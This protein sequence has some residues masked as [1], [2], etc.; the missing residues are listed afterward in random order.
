MDYQYFEAIHGSKLTDDSRDCALKEIKNRLESDLR[1]SMNYESKTLVNNISQPLIV[2]PKKNNGSVCK[3]Q[4]MPNGSFSLGDYIDYDDNKWLVTDLQSGIKAQTF[5]TMTK[6]N[7]K[8]CFQNNDRIIKEYWGIIDAK[9]SEVDSGRVI[10]TVA[11][12]LKCLLPFNNDTRRIFVDKR[13]IIG[14]GFNR[15]ENKIPFVY[16]VTGI[17]HCS[18]EY[19][20][21]NI[22]TLFM[23]RDIATK[24]D[25]I[26]HMVADYVPPSSDAPPLYIESKIEG[27]S[28]VRAGGS[29]RPLEAV[30]FLPLSSVATDDSVVPVWDV[31]YPEILDDKLTFQTNGNF[32]YI[33]V[34]DNAQIGEKITVKLKDKRAR[35]ETVSKVLEVV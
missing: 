34:A 11:G 12:S 6:C 32:I 25:S 30:F 10:S 5:G 13:F 18:Q 9:A 26:E 2:I 3:I 33:S 16:K 29:P 17:Q 22:V 24:A 20:S 1:T 28:V 7:Y 27:K 4:S 8:F 15:N 23:E 31:T 19:G 14:S 35:Y 21:C